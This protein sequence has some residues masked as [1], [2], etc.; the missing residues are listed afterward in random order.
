MEVRDREVLHLEWRYY[1]ANPLALFGRKSSGSIT[2]Q[3]QW[4]HSAANQ[5]APYGRELTQANS[6][7]EGSRESR[8]RCREPKR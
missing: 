2:P 5:M 1:A 4:L 8:A 7:K 3:I 6:D